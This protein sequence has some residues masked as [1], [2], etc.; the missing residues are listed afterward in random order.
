M[1][2]E[3]AAIAALRLRRLWEGDRAFRSLTLLA[4]IAVMM[5]AAGLATL[6]VWDSRL[7]WQRLGAGFI[8]G[9]TW[10]PVSGEYGALP[11]LYGTVYSSALA[12]L[13][14]VPLGI[15]SAVFLTEA[16]PQRVAGA[17]TF[18]IELIA[19]VPSVILGLMGM[20]VL[21]PAV[22]FVEPTLI[23]LLG[24][25]PFFRGA[26]YGVG[27][28]AAG[29]ILSFMILPYITVISREAMLAVPMQVREAALGLGATKWEMVR[30]A[31]LPSARAGIG[32]AVL[33]ALGRALG[34]T[35]AVTMV[36]GNTPKISPSLMDPGYTMAAVLA[37]EFAEASQDEYLHALVGVGL[38]LFGLTLFANA[39]G[40]WLL[41]RMQRSDAQ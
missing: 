14:A 34:E 20:F 13:I 16:A 9:T 22:R 6:L 8:W 25:T 28:L 2:G 3:G 24:W 4:G 21:V 11:F 40:R 7:A 32:A 23:A 41:S 15:G 31:V 35:M 1:S 26:A 39:G 5:L 38:V 18:L 33:L 30:M 29:L 36:I 37:N 12:L 10:D 27:M 17:L 19:A